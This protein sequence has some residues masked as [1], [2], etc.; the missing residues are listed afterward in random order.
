MAKTSS[1]RRRTELR[2]HERQLA[3]QRE[4]EQRVMEA[5]RAT[6]PRSSTRARLVLA[7]FLLGFAALVLSGLLFAPGRIGSQGSEGR[8]LLVLLTGLTTG[9]LS[10][11]AV[12]GG[13]LATAVVQREEQDL[14]QVADETPLEA[15][16][17]VVG[18]DGQV[19][20]QDEFALAVERQRK[21]LRKQAAL[22]HNSA[23][24]IWFLVAKLAVYTLLGAGLGWLGSQLQPSITMR[25]ILQIAAA[26]FM[27]ATA[28]HLLKVHPIFRYVM[29]QPPMF[30]TRRI[31]NRA[32]S[33]DIFAPAILGAMT[34]FMPCGITLAMQLLAINSGSA[35]RG[36]AVMFAF[37]LGTS[38]LFFVLGVLAV[39][40]GDALHDRFLKVA[41]VAVLGLGLWS[42]DAALRIMGSPV[43]VAKAASAIVT[44]T[45]PVSASIAADGVQ[46]ARINV[47]ARSYRPNRYTIKAG[48]PARVVFANNGSQGCTSGL[49]WQDQVYS[50]PVTGE[51]VFELEPREQGDDIDYVCAMG[52]YGGSIKVV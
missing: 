2:Q 25:G 46:E 51:K 4:W 29:L 32:K 1:K 33:K 19:V 5:A 11:L 28:L 13:L 23:P 40:M 27:I 31:R 9:G 38:P 22:H 42:A 41:A 37:V 52:M 49:V 7:L 36:A 15:P 24:V 16:E 14:E 43:S 34:I 35:A 10:C 39:R 8:L 47:E 12:Q 21:I 30:I 18:R 26:L 44:A 20:R 6:M 45:K 48:K 50:L 3:N 17:P